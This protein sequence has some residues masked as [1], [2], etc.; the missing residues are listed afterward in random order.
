MSVK[1]KNLCKGQAIVKINLGNILDADGHW[2]RALDSFEEGYRI[3]VEANKIPVQIN[4][5]ENMHYVHMIRFNNV[6]EAR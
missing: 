3:A 6:E 2:T 5:L 4:A 1:P